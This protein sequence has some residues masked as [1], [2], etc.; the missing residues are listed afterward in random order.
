MVNLNIATLALL[1]PSSH[2]FSSLPSASFRGNHLFGVQ[3]NTKLFKSNTD[4]TEA[5]EAALDAS[6]KFGATSKEARVLWDIVEEI[7]SSDNR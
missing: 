4:S 5:I 7:S 1:F 2:A 3:S 6:K